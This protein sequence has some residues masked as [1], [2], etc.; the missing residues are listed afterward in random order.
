MKNALRS[1]YVRQMRVSKIFPGFMEEYIAAL[2][3][4]AQKFRVDAK[5]HQLSHHSHD[6][7]K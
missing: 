1:L 3:I 5:G 4:L 2:R 6:R 7:K